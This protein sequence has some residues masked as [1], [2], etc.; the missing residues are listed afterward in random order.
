MGRLAGER[1][2]RL[3]AEGWIVFWQAQTKLVRGRFREAMAHPPNFSD[4]DPTEINPAKAVGK[5]TFL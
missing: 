3:N 2:R 5:E 1:P 4:H